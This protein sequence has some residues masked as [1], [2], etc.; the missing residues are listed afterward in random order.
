MKAS[1]GVKPVIS[2]KT[3]LDIGSSI[4]EQSTDVVCAEDS[5]GNRLIYEDIGQVKDESDNACGE[6]IVS[7]W[8]CSGPSSHVEPTPF[9]LEPTTVHR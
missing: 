8:P 6:H 7:A 4:P 3:I 2:E 1:S 9:T 5:Q